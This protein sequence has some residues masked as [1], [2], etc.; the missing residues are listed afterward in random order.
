LRKAWRLALACALAT[1]C[2]HFFGPGE[3]CSGA[4]A[5]TGPPRTLHVRAALR[6]AGHEVRHEAVVQVEP[7]RIRVVGLTPM[8]TQAFA[9]TREDGRL[10]VDNRVGRHLGQSPE[11]LFDA[12][13]HAYLAG[14][15]A[16][17]APDASAGSRD[18]AV[19]VYEPGPPPG[20]R[21]RSAACDYEAWI[22]VVSDET[23]P[24]AP[25]P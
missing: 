22:A 18:D 7:G 6:H 10:E 15:A 12:V 5:R 2:Q 16:G 9:L 3:S 23:E 24:P 20:A 8:G 14:L 19:V 11:L 25:W 1:G 13:A 17:A 21:V 4:V